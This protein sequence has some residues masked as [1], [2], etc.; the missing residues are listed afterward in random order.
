MS[1]DYDV[2]N[3]EATGMKSIPQRLLVLGG[4]RSASRWRRRRLPQARGLTRFAC[5]SPARASSLR[6]S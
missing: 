3:R 2:V 4:G 5:S 6:Q 1:A